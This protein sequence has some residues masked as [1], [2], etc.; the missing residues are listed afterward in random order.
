MRATISSS[1]ATT[2]ADAPAAWSLWVNIPRTEEVYELQVLGK[3]GARTVFVLQ[4]SCKGAGSGSQS[5]QL[6]KRYG[7]FERVHKLATKCAEAGGVRPPELPRRKLIW[8]RDPKY[9]RTLREQLQLYLEQVIDLVQRTTVGSLDLATVLQQLELP[10]A[11]ESAQW[12][13]RARF[14]VAA[15]C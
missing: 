1:R 12:E 14:G 10:I 6:K 3:V 11:S 5:W 15:D 4:V 8:R 7:Y 2:I 13:Q 9:L